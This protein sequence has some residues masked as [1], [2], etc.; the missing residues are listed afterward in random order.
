MEYYLIFLQARDIT[1]PNEI[2]KILNYCLENYWLHCNILTQNSQGEVLI[3]TYFPYSRTY[4]YQA[5][6][7]LINRFD[8]EKF[9]S[10]ILFPKKLS[11]LYNCP[12]K[13][14]TWEVP[15]YV[16]V[17]YLENG[18]TELKG[19]DMFVLRSLSEDMLFSMDVKVLNQSEMVANILKNGSDLGPLKAVSESDIF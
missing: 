5:K 13:I 2:E 10:N 8:G 6:P 18:K 12:L 14:Y 17:K 16:E 4:C 3:H 9:V 15:P 11:N 1:V 7:R 19:L